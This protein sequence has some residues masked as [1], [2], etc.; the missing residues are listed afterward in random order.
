MTYG[1]IGYEAFVDANG[2]KAHDG[3]PMPR[4]DELP[5]SIV[6]A[7]EAAATAVANAHAKSIA[8]ARDDAEPV[9]N[10]RPGPP[11]RRLA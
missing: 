5:A 2:G 7:W 6:R 11:R 9:T 1:Q 4:W 10:P 3:R 8:R